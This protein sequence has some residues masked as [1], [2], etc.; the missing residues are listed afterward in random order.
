MMMCIK[1]SLHT[2]KEL[3]Q[4]EM[5]WVDSK[6]LCLMSYH[7]YHLG[8]MKKYIDVSKDASVMVFLDTIVSWWIWPNE[9]HNSSIDWQY[10]SIV[11][12]VVKTGGYVHLVIWDMGDVLQATSLFPLCFLAV[13]VLI[14]LLCQT[15]LTMS[16]NESFCHAVVSTSW[17]EWWKCNKYTILSKTWLGKTNCNL[18]ICGNQN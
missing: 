2:K 5:I 8:W 7:I 17:T 10:N 11:V 9:W 14:A 15:S 4:S 3:F 12:D 1:S 13:M 18:I 16:N 6:K